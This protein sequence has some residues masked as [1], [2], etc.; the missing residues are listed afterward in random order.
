[1]EGLPGAGACFV[2][3]EGFAAGLDGIEMEDFDVGRHDV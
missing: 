3:V 1:M 2:W